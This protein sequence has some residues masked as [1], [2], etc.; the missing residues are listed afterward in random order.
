MLRV[1]FWRFLHILALTGSALQVIGYFLP[2]ARIVNYSTNTTIEA[3]TYWMP[4]VHPAVTDTAH[5]VEEL[6]SLLVFLGILVP[7]GVAAVELFSRPRR[8]SPIHLLSIT[9]AIFWF[10]QYIIVAFVSVVALNICPSDECPQGGDFG[11][12]FLPACIGSLLVIGCFIA[13]FTLGYIW[14]HND[15]LESRSMAQKV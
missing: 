7:L 3:D 1:Y 2:F 10:V 9:V 12:G 5:L 4:F 8:S 13:L 6:F 14:W 11:S 15:P